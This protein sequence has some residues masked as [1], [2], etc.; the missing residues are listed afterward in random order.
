LAVE[1]P[2]GGVL[3]QLVG[4]AHAVREAARVIVS[5][6]PKS[7]PRYPPR[8]EL[9]EIWGF[10]AAGKAEEALAWLRRSGVASHSAIAYSSYYLSVVAQTLALAQQTGDALDVINQALHQ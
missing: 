10:A 4:N 6:V 1:W 5:L 3:Q 8:A 9:F 7:N 2:V